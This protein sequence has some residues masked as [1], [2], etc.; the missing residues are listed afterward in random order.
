M[1]RRPPRST[2][3]PYTTLFRSIGVIATALRS[4]RRVAAQ[5]TRASPSTDQVARLAP[6]LMAAI[7]GVDRKSTRL[8]SS[9]NPKSYSLFFF[10][11]KKRTY[12][13]ANIHI[14]LTDAT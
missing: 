8:N 5:W 2:L 14:T 10:E 12:N 9:H 13:C 7:L 1:I 11:K 6:S 4:L 3:F